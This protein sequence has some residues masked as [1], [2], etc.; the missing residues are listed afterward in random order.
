MC[1]KLAIPGVDKQLMGLAR[2]LRTTPVLA[3][4][5]MIAL[6]LLPRSSPANSDGWFSKSRVQLGITYSIFSGA[7]EHSLAGNSQAF[8]AQ[9][10]AERGADMLAFVG[11]V[12]ADFGSG[13]LPFNDGGTSRTLS[14]SH[15]AVDFGV[16]LKLFPIPSGRGF[17]V[18][19]YISGLGEVGIA[20]LKFNT[21]SL[22]ALESSYSSIALGYT[23]SAGVQMGPSKDKS[24]GWNFFTEIA[25]RRAT[26]DLAGDSSF[27]LNCIKLVG[28]VGW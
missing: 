5:I 13:S 18:R 2:C 6:L 28:G 3:L 20:S 12:R 9:L 24:G 14:F 26:A 17:P 10:S 4:I 7:A 8:G 16:G 19:P 11:R 1:V 27:N 23:L 22:T 21:S 25:L 15:Y